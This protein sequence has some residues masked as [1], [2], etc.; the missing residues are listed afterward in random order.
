M[1]LTTAQINELLGIKESYKASDRLMEILFDSKEKRESLFKAFLEIEPN[2]DYDWFH[3]YFQDEHA[4]R[5]LK[6]QDF[7]PR[8]ITDLLVGLAGA[9]DTYFEATAGTGGIV[10]QHWWQ[11]PFCY[12]CVEELSDRAFPF[13]LFNLAIRNINGTAYHGD[14]LTQEWENVYELT[15]G[16]QF[17][18]ITRRGAL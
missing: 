7:T 1:T 11:S 10:I 2:L 14:S 16:E 5:K 18:D 12:Y 17:S 6:K 15:I 9:S 3:V 8:G 13:L 4:D